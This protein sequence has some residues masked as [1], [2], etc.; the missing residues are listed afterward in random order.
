MTEVPEPLIQRRVGVLVPPENPTVEQ[1]F[2]DLLSPDM[3]F[4]TARLPVVQGNLRE[5]LLAYNESLADMSGAFA[6]MSLSAL[7]LACT[8]S[9]YLVSPGGEGSLTGPMGSRGAHPM[10][11]AG[12]VTQSLRSLDRRRLAIVSPYPDWL[13]SLA[14]EYWEHA[15]FSVSNVVKVPAP[16]GIYALSTDDVVAHIRQLPRRESDVILLSG[17][18][19]PTCDA[20]LSIG[21][22]MGVPVISSNIASAAC[23]HA[24]C[25]ASGGAVDQLLAP[26]W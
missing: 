16:A 21:T 1:E 15:G 24:L 10:T 18:G 22:S 13:T 4:H 19:M 11:A 8:G 2:R 9:S 25:G 23:L 14:V 7:L 20:A 12:A 6:N 26:W 17:T 5:R 3:S